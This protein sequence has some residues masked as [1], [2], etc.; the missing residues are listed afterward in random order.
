MDR[1]IELIGSIVFLSAAKILAGSLIGAVLYRFLKAPL[2]TRKGI[3]TH[4]MGLIFF[5]SLFGVLLPLDSYAVVPI[6][7]GLFACGFKAYEVLPLFLSNSL[8]SMIV[9]LTEIGYQWSV[10]LYRLVFAIVIGF[11]GGLVIKALGK[12]G[13]DAVLYKLIKGLAPKGEGIRELG[14]FVVISTAG[15]LVLAVLGGVIY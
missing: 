6:I 3:L 7:I 15:F 14:R 4:P 2:Q 10:G 8:F 11:V 1:L 12:Q 5:S 13:E 9:P